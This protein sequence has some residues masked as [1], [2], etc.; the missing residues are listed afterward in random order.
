M[1]RNPPA[2]ASET[3]GFPTN[4]SLDR[5]LELLYR[6]ID[7]ERFRQHEHPR[8]FKLNAM[9]SLLRELGN[10]QSRYRIV[11]VAGT[12]GKGSVCQMIAGSLVQSGIRTGR[13]SSPHILHLNERI[14]VDGL[15]IPD[16][17]LAGAGDRSEGHRTSGSPPNDQI[18][19][20]VAQL[21]RSHYGHRAAVLCPP[22][23]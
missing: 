13:Y 7:Y 6:R 23:R 1:P 8:Y 18:P 10:P 21:L 14:E 20:A 2:T 15:A 9:R 17:H 16:D 11:H 5:E 4:S 12:K 19:T 3:P 22:G